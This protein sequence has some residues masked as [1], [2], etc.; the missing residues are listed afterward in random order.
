MQMGDVCIFSVY[1]NN[2]FGPPRNI[3]PD[4]CISGLHLK[5]SRPRCKKEEEE[6]EYSLWSILVI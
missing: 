4:G 1:H 5:G 2:A 3:F 6:E